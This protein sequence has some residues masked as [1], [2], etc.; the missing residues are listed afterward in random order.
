MAWQNPQTGKMVK[1]NADGTWGSKNSRNEQMEAAGYVW[2][3]DGPDNPEQSFIDAVKARQTPEQRAENDKLNEQ[4][5]RQQRGEAAHEA[6]NAEIEAARLAALK[7]EYPRFSNWFPATVKKIAKEGEVPFMTAAGSDDVYSLP[8][9]IIGA[10]IDH[11]RGRPFLSNLGVT[12]EESGYYTDDDGNLQRRG[13]VDAF[14]QGIGRD[15]MLVPSIPIGGGVASGLRSLGVQGIKNGGMLTRFLV[16]DVL[17]PA[18]EG[19]L[20]GATTEAARPFISAKEFDRGEYLG[21][22]GMGALGGA[23]LN[24]GL[25]NLSGL[26]K[27]GFNK[28]AN[29]FKTA[30]KTMGEKQAIINDDLVNK[31]KPINEIV[32]N[33]I[34]ENEAFENFLKEKG[35]TL[36]DLYMMENPSKSGKPIENQ[37]FWDMVIA[38]DNVNSTNQFN[39]APLEWKLEEI[40][41][42]ANMNPNSL[43]NTLTADGVASMRDLHSEGILN[44]SKRHLTNVT[45]SEYGP[46][47]IKDAKHAFMEEHGDD[48]VN[49]QAI[50]EL[51]E[52]MKRF[53]ERNMTG[54][55]LSKHHKPAKN[56]MDEYVAK[57]LEPDG[58]PKKITLNEWE[59]IRNEFG[60]RKAD[61]DGQL[62][63]DKISKEGKRDLDKVY[64]AF[65]KE[66]F[67]MLSPEAQAAHN[68]RAE[69]KR[70]HDKIIENMSKTGIDAAPINYGTKISNLASEAPAKKAQWMEWLRNYDKLNGTNLANEA[71]NYSFA[72]NIMGGAEKEV[73]FGFM[74]INLHKTGRALDPNSLTVRQA[75]IL[76]NYYARKAAEEQARNARGPSSNG[77]LNLG[78]IPREPKPSGGGLA[79]LSFE[80]V[81]VKA[82]PAPAMAVPIGSPK[83]N[84]AVMPPTLVALGQG[85]LVTKPMYQGKP[86]KWNSLQELLI[87]GDSD[88]NQN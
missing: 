23:G 37:D 3:E 7:E 58:T 71:K 9:R 57:L 73:P 79:S 19:A 53:E 2:I 38:Q 59:K 56:I 24:T 8:G 64:D 61:F 4:L 70:A 20:V 16:N 85:G 50:K 6:M 21:D 36:D 72:Q 66:S 5:Y 10:S 25:K 51:G 87:Y 46:K 65:K 88:G 86:K 62:N 14:M 74:D 41:H 29:K 11:L 54:G 12:H 75:T 33:K 55:T 81:E 49:P 52:Y 60:G 78:K 63:L 67:N 13:G 83:S 30:K 77:G 76:A 28:L 80:P 1:K 48:L 68:K 47:G 84:P 43:K 69:F 40:G 17:I 34:S 27:F 31:G 22:I 39:K 35:I 15:P 45:E 82:L 26:A 18:S 44:I 32:D 42:R